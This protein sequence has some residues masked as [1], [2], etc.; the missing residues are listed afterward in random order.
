MSSPGSAGGHAE[1][2]S[3]SVSSL[4][5]VGFERSAVSD[6]TVQQDLLRLQRE[7]DEAQARK[8]RHEA[9]VHSAAFERDLA[10]FKERQ[11]LAAEK[12]RA[13]EQQRQLVTDQAAALEVQRQAIA[14]QQQQLQEALRT[15]DLNRQAA[16]LA[17]EQRERAQAAANLRAAAEEAR[18]AE[19]AQALEA[20]NAI[21]RLVEQQGQLINEAALVLG[22]EGA[23]LVPVLAV[24]RPAEQPVAGPM[25]VAVEQPAREGGQP[26]VVQDQ[27]VEQLIVAD[28]PPAAVGDPP[29]G[30]AELPQVG[31][32]SC[33]SPF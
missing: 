14:L 24:D 21:G 31:V 4:G 1:E 18:L 16:A 8:W 20:A 17:Q 25:V 28:D 6:S 33:F 26:A 32:F 22:Q 2:V 23:V 11:R 5:C 9:A 30:P 29:A 19:E 3:G 27:P 7:E 13:V 10:I 15:L 12:E